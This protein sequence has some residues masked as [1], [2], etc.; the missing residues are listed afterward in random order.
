MMPNGEKFYLGLA[1]VQL[2]QKQA[3][4]FFDPRKERL[5]EYDISRAVS[6]VGTP[7]KPVIGLI[8]PLPVFGMPSN[9]MMMRMGQQGQEPWMI[10]NEL[11]NDFTVKNVG[12]DVD[13]IEDDV[14]VL[15]LIHPRDIT[16]K[17]QFALDQFILRG[18][19]MIAF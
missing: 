11:K 7:E 10:V 16:E 6:R 14:Q 12:M 17:A 18:G 5:L 3:I 15:V 8:T 1:V 4:P 13:K 2:E 9:P 19:K